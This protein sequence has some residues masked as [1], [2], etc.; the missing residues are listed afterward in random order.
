MFYANVMLLV[1]IIDFIL[2]LDLQY[3]WTFYT[4]FAIQKEPTH[5]VYR[6]SAK[7]FR[8][9]YLRPAYM[10]CTASNITRKIS[11]SFSATFATHFSDQFPATV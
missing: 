1:L 11:I 3:L 7:P 5:R 2:E 9:D 6:K 4:I 8:L 10:H